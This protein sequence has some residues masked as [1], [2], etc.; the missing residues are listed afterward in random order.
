MDWLKKHF[1][2]ALYVVLMM[3]GMILNLNGWYLVLGTFAYLILYALIKLP[4]T[5]AFIGYFLQAGPHKYDAAFACY[6][7]AYKKG[8]VVP[9]P[10]L[11]YGIQLLER[12]QYEKALKVMQDVLGHADAQ[13]TM[14]IYADVTK[15]LR[16]RELRNFS[17][18][19][20]KK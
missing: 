13:T 10:M 8:G 14:N 15:D 17:D 18:S 11:A 2:L 12:S 1:F 5:V 7:Y 9:G 3:V 19:F 6:E 4:K 16:D 20:G